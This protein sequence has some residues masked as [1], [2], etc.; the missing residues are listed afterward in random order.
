MWF[1]GLGALIFLIQ[2][3]G[4]QADCPA[5]GLDSL[6]PPVGLTHN[7]EPTDSVPNGFF[8]AYKCDS[9]D[10]M[11]LEPDPNGDGIFPVTCGPDDV[12]ETPTEWFQCVK[13]CQVPG[14]QPSYK[15]QPKNTPMVYAGSSLT[16]KCLQPGG[17]VD[18]TT[19]NAH[20]ITCGPDGTFPSTPWPTCIVRCLVPAP[21]SGYE[22]S[23]VAD[24]VDVGATLTFSCAE[25][26]HTVGGT[27]SRDHAITCGSNGKFPTGWPKCALKCDVPAPEAGY[28]AQTDNT[29][30]TLGGKLKFYCETEGQTIGSTRDTFYEVTCGETG[31]FPTGWPVCSTKCEVPRDIPGFSN[32]PSDAPPMEVDEIK[33]YTCQ[34]TLM[35]TG[36]AMS[37][38][39]EITC[40]ADGSISPAEWP[41]CGVRCQIP[42][43]Q[44]GYKPQ[45]SGVAPPGYGESLFFECEEPGAKVG[46]TTS[47]KYEVTCRGD[48]SFDTNWPPCS[49]RCV[50][51]YGETGYN[52]QPAGT[53]TIEVGGELAYSCMETGALSG[54]TALNTH[55]VT[56]GSDGTF[57]TGW[58]PCQIRCAV[59]EAQAGY[60]GPVDPPGSIDVGESVVFSC[61]DAEAEV[62]STQ[63]NQLM[64]TCAAD[65][66]LATIWPPCLIPATCPTPPDLQATNTSLVL[67]GDTPS[68]VK[69]HRKVQ[70]ECPDG[71]TT[72]EGPVISLACQPDGTYADRTEWPNCREKVVCN[73]SIPIPSP[74]SGLANSTSTIAFE[75]DKVEYSC[76]NTTLKINGQDTFSLTCGINGRLPDPIN[77]P[78]CTNPNTVFTSDPVEVCHCLGEIDDVDKAKE[79][80]DKVCREG[81][82]TKADSG[83][84]GVS[85]K[86]CGTKDL[87]AITEA[88]K[89]FCDSPLEQSAKGYW[90][91][92]V[93]ATQPWQW[94]MNISHP[95]NLSYL[96]NPHNK[97]FK[98][99]QSKLEKA[100][101]AKFFAAGLSKYV[102]SALHQFKKGKEVPPGVFAESKPVTEAATIAPE[103]EIGTVCPASLLTALN[104]PTHL[105]RDGS[106]DVGA[107]EKAIYKC[108]T[109][110]EVLFTEA[111]AAGRVFNDLNQVAL[112]CASD[113][114]AF[115]GAPATWPEC[116]TITD[117]CT[118]LVPAADS[119]MDPQ[120]P[121][122]TTVNVGATLDYS[123]SDAGHVVAGTTDNKYT[124]KCGVFGTETDPWYEAKFTD[125]ATWPKCQAAVAR[126]RK[127]STSG[128]N[129]IEVEMQAQFHDPAVSAADV[130]AVVET[131]QG[132]LGDELILQTDCDPS[133]CTVEKK[134][135]TCSNEYF[136][137]L[138]IGYRALTPY[139]YYQTA[140]AP[141]LV[142]ANNLVE[143]GQIVELR[144]VSTD[145]M[146]YPLWDNQDHDGNDRK[147]TVTCL[148]PSIPGQRGEWSLKEVPKCASICK[149]FLPEADFESDLLL[150]KVIPI[151]DP[152]NPVD[153]TEYNK[154][155][156]FLYSGD[157][158]LYVC[159]T[160]Y[161]GVHGGTDEFH[162]EFGC[163]DEGFLNTPQ[164]S[165]FEDPWPHCAPQQQ[166]V[167]TAVEKMLDRF[168]RRI[169][170]RFKLIEFR[171]I[172]N[173]REIVQ[174]SNYVLEVTLPVVLS[175]LLF[176]LVVCACSRP[177][178]PMCKLCESKV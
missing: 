70:Y 152:T 115:T 51:P 159:K 121:A 27:N 18:G 134:P 177:G 138:P 23:T 61:A 178:S 154:T 78:T 32:P 29:P 20:T 171:E 163:T 116:R 119:G 105:V 53:P 44:E 133:V 147:L 80:L 99:L 56:C 145:P 77:W 40:M 137:Q 72:D 15:A 93:L 13:K 172:D 45:E 41:M 149:Q 111:G 60:E 101:D 1:E 139:G 75:G 126:R 9:D 91:R 168:D 106:G 94:T 96:Q 151:R 148:A 108:S 46:N 82:M 100:V 83:K 36:P 59:P 12:F 175:L 88:N 28:K 158:L 21:E 85:R 129:Y 62:G 65:G 22:A 117:Q 155:S 73:D 153:Y 143:K 130:Q 4:V 125:P 173:E 102:R 69:A 166:M 127:R 165:D 84:I 110:T 131:L 146:Q 64:L 174:L 48:G 3:I 55:T 140:L 10:N 123:C 160:E 118:V 156:S 112:T 132:D 14:A 71:Q 2:W 103:D 66:S 35:S 109:G 7:L 141:S 86:R 26:G 136:E 34:N 76:S 81:A 124:V 39:H 144:C 5:S 97:K 57:P 6:S 68:P 120:D 164:G 38:Q 63:S 90:F 50:P 128:Y 169:S 142:N 79:L 24:P 74:T 47:N 42:T 37:N 107:G 87:E 122:T 25:P 150:Q 31:T 89:C 43:P 167:V 17:L 30:V 98:S 176:V 58:P 11:H 19:S 54:D 113:G 104:I 92:V 114:S 95:Q 67:K 135:E 8:A 33:I 161:W 157:K 16:Y 162:D 170:D 49:V 52:S